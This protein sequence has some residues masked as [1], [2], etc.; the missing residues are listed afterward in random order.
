MKSNNV[1]VKMFSNF[2]M[3]LNGEILTDE[4]LRSNMILKLLAYML[5]HRKSIINANELSEILWK[6]DESDNPIGALKNLMY[7]LRSILSKKYNDVTFIKTLRGSYAWSEEIHVVMDAEVFESRYKASKTELDIHKKAA[8]LDEALQLY[9]G[10]FL[11]KFS[12]EHWIMQLAA[13]YHSIYITC[14]KDLCELYDQLQEY[15]KMEL[16][17]NH[18]IKL[19]DLDESIHCMLMKA[20]L[21]QGKKVA[22][23]DHYKRT[24]Q[25]LYSQLGT[26]PSA[27]MVGFYQELMKDMKEEQMDLSLIQE[28]LQDDEIDNGAFYCEYGV[29]KEIYSLQA[30]QGK[31]LGIAVFCALITVESALK[32]PL[33]SESYRK[34]RDTSMERLLSVIKKTLRT[35]DVFTRYS[36]IQYMVLL[37]TCSYEGGNVALERIKESYY[38]LD[39]RHAADLICDLKEQELV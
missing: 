6:E 36:A 11:S 33:D 26:K 32:L 2:E 7:R 9:T 14:V 34:F 21:K 13:Y 8:L 12:S 10:Q 39:T 16:V 30:R 20:L 28:D 35:G 1:N 27:E 29:F 3:D 18:A 22:A 38:M 24:S 31:R 37:P 19:E 4:T 17:C 15:E 5:C 25:L 23:E